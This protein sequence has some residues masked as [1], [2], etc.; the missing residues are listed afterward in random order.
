MKVFYTNI[1]QSLLMSNLNKQKK[2]PT[3][4]KQTISNPQNPV[5]K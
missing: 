3:V 5:Y 4:N 2:T 1:P